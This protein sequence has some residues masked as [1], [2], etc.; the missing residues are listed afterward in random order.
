MTGA[1]KS[2]MGSLEYPEVYTRRKYGVVLEGESSSPY[3]GEAVG[4]GW[5]VTDGHTLSV[6][7]KTLTKVQSIEDTRSCPYA[8]LVNS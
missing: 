7:Y 8:R 2:G 4:L 3:E 6:L 5:M 1:T